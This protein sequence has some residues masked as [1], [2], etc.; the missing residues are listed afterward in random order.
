M[1][2]RDLSKEVAFEL[3]SK[4]KAAKERYG[5]WLSQAEEKP[6]WGRAWG[7]PRNRR[8]SSV[9]GSWMM[10]RVVRNKVKVASKAKSSGGLSQYRMPLCYVSNWKVCPSTWKLAGYCPHKGNP[11]NIIASICVQFCFLL[12]I[13][14]H[15]IGGQGTLM[16]S[17]LVKWQKTNELFLYI[18]FSIC[19]IKWIELEVLSNLWFYIPILASLMYNENRCR[20]V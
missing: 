4:W 7:V 11:S 12:V 6:R 14:K 8:K 2:K 1:V 13:I 19:K 15:K 18:Y 3:E 20:S 9:T 5:G 16:W 10:G 17:L